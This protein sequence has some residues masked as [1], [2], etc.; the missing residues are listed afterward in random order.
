M[1]FSPDGNNLLTGSDTVRA[2]DSMTGRELHEIFLPFVAPEEQ[3]RVLGRAISRLQDRG[4]ILSLAFSSDGNKV[5]VGRWGGNVNLIGFLTGERQIELYIS[6]H[7]DSVAFSGDGNLLVT[8]TGNWL[9][10]YERDGNS[11]RPKANRHLPVIWP[12]T[13]RFLPE[14]PDCKRCVEVARDVPENQIKL[15]RIN[16]DE[17]PL[18]AIKGDPKQL[19]AEWSAKLG[20]TFDSRG[21]IVPLTSNPPK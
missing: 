7:A 20:L 14:R 18:P 13:L 21:R 4:S 16:F 10:L 9:H 12:N 5:A 8:Q 19:L 6:G 3:T 2:F 11:W 15:D 17:F 1:V